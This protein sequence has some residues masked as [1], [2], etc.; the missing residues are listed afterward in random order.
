MFGEQR[1]YALE[2]ELGVGQ[3]A[4][5]SSRVPECVAKRCR[6]LR[7]VDLV[8]KRAL[9]DVRPLDE[10]TRDDHAGDLRAHLDV[11]RGLADALYTEVRRDRL[12]RHGHHRD[13]LRREGEPPRAG[14][15]TASPHDERQD[16]RAAGGEN[17]VAGTCARPSYTVSVHAALS[18]GATR[19]FPVWFRARYPVEMG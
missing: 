8:E 9:G 5:A 10:R 3:R 11:L 6:V 2:I 12:R 16:R 19:W 15:A 17:K 18:E 13:L 14:A 4:F 7:R 1:S